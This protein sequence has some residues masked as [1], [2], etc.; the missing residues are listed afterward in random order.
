M[1]TIRPKQHHSRF[2][3]LTMVATVALTTVPAWQATAQ[4]PAA[5]TPAQPAPPPA[6]TPATVNQTNASQSSEQR[7]PQPSA[8]T[9][10]T[11]IPKNTPNVDRYGV[12]SKD[13]KATNVFDYKTAIPGQPQ[14]SD[15]PVLRTVEES[16]AVALAKN[17][18]LLIAE[19]RAVRTRST[20]RQIYALGYPQIQTSASYTRLSGLGA[21]FGGGG[22]T[23]TPA[24]VQNPFPVGLQVTPP[25]T[26]PI[27]LSGNTGTGS[28]GATPPGGA[29]QQGAAATTGAAGA[30][31]AGQTRSVPAG[32][33]ATGNNPGTT[34]GDNTPG[35]NPGGQTPG[36]GTPGQNPQN[37]NQGGN[38]GGFGGGGRAQL[39]Q[40]VVR[41]SVAQ[42]VDITGIVRTAIQVGQ[43]EQA[44]T[45]L[46]I[47]RTRMDVA[48]NVRTAFYNV[49][50]SQA[51]VRVNEAAVAQSEELVRVTEAQLR[52]GVASQFDVLRARTQ[53]E[54]NRQALISSRNQV[55]IAKNAFANTVGIDPSTPVDAQ[56]PQIPALPALDEQPLVNRAFEQRP[57]YVQADINILKAQKNVRLARR[58]LEPFLNVVAGGQ[59]NPRPALVANERVTGSVGATLSL[60]LYDG[61]A[62]RAQV[63]AARSDE[64]GAL[65]QKDQFV[66]GIKAEVQQS[67]IAVRDADERATVSQTTVTQAREA[68][69]LANVRFQAGVGT[70]LDVNDAQTA[71]TQAET[72]QVN[73]TY[74][75][76]GALA[77]LSRAVGNPE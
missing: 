51:F 23:V 31:G 71:L 17:P 33:Q 49:L 8:Q 38:T 68:L 10:P 61:G 60:P 37:P 9:P 41:A 36:T 44:L 34:P 28:A 13:V 70:Q 16:I 43:L 24:Q 76:L 65:I 3:P 20:V 63:D 18:N 73:A 53:L 74:D 25:G 7:V 14:A 21:A 12:R 45:Q 58:T 6:T 59:F 66:R 48:L 69:R 35:Q 54:N 4:Q 30:T 64:R 39:D 19:E 52:A 72:N 27:T 40:Y 77:R 62:T 56:S 29:T 50:R 26:V 67:I 11:P 57:E 42:F 5:Q 22:G 47:A 1:N 2:R 46:E 32:R 15:P 55:A 75:Y